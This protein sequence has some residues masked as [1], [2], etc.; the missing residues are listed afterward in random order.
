MRWWSGGFGACMFGIAIVAQFIQPGGW[1]MW[2][3]LALLLGAFVCWS[4]TAPLMRRLL[5]GD[6]EENVPW[7]TC[8]W[9]GT[10]SR[11]PDDVA[12]KYCA[13]CHEFEDDRRLREE[14]LKNEGQE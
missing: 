5:N 1:T 7:Y 10:T 4:R 12:N 6:G 2:L 3:A 9:C 13:R 14:L 11:H 8:P